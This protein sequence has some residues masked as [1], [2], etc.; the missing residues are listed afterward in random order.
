MTKKQ[1]DELTKKLSKEEAD[2]YLTMPRLSYHAF[3]WA[4][5][6]LY[7]VSGVLDLLR[8]EWNRKG[9][10]DERRSNHNPNV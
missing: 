1:L 7:C 10:S 5:I 2:L 8:E 3:N 6:R 9:Y 4:K